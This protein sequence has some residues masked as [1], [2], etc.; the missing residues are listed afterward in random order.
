MKFLGRIFFHVRV[1]VCVIVDRVARARASRRGNA[2]GEK[3]RGVDEREILD[4]EKT[5][6]RQYARHDPY[7]RARVKRLFAE[8]DPAPAVLARRRGYRHRRYLALL[9][10][11]LRTVHDPRRINAHIGRRGI[12]L[13]GRADAHLRKDNPSACKF[14][15]DGVS[16][17]RVIWTHKN[18]LSSAETECEFRVLARRVGFDRHRRAAREL[19]CRDYIRALSLRRILSRLGAG[20]H[21]L[22][23]ILLA[24]VV[25]AGALV[26]LLRIADLRAAVAVIFDVRIPLIRVAFPRAEFVFH[27][28]RWLNKVWIAHRRRVDAGIS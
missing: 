10:T 1:A 3:L 24:P 21:N 16:D 13:A 28:F 17:L 12:V 14:V 7:A 4:I 6:R 15:R 5:R 22:A 25:P 26:A 27:L 18:P 20:G 2:L 19:F 8:R 9:A 23:E 11:D